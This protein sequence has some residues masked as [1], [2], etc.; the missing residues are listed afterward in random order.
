MA[1]GGIIEEKDIG[2]SIGTNGTF[3]NTELTEDGKV[4]L[5]IVGVTESG[6]PHYV[7]EG[8]WVS[9][10]IN[11]GDN[12]KELRTVQSNLKNASSFKLRLS[13]KLVK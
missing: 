9:E 7:T 2:L 13:L 3:N 4:R 12:F 1:V 6:E 11:I 8:E 5:K 10:I